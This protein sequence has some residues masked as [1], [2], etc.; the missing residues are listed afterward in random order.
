MELIDVRNNVYYVR[1]GINCKVN[2]LDSIEGLNIVD[3]REEVNQKLELFK[4]KAGLVALKLLLLNNNKAPEYKDLFDKLFIHAYDLGLVTNKNQMSVDYVHQGVLFG[5]LLKIVTFDSSKVQTKENVVKSL[6]ELSVLDENVVELSRYGLQALNCMYLEI[7]N[8]KVYVTELVKFME[9]IMGTSFDN[10][11]Y[12]GITPSNKLFK[13]VV[14]Q[15]YSKTC[16][17]VAFS[18]WTTFSN[19]RKERKL[20]NSKSV[21]NYVTY[22]N[23]IGSNNASFYC[24]KFSYKDYSD[25]LSGNG[26][27]IGRYLKSK[28]KTLRDVYVE[29]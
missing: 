23:N 20:L 21:R 5:N 29:Q 12:I 24:T 9:A 15:G 3:I 4:A 7:G 10:V 2:K 16:C 28:Y 25:Y 11:Q 27:S 17:S 22:V 13:F 18:D 8:N 14:T 1:E 19:K 6:D 26:E